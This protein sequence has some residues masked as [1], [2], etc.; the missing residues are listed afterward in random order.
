VRNVHGL[1]T[2][3]PAFNFGTTRVG[4]G[5]DLTFA[6]AEQFSVKC[7][8]HPWMLASVHVF[9][10][11]YFAATDAAGAFEIGGVPPG[12]YTL[13]FAHHFLQSAE[14]RVTVADGRVAEADFTYQKAK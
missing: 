8:V 6:R 5:R 7:D 11:P 4:H 10:H 9:D 14:R 12:E 1:S 2:L 13:V 3:N